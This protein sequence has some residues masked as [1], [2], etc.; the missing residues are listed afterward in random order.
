MP[1]VINA[2][3]GYE[4]VR[5]NTDGKWHN[6]YRGVD[7]GM[8]GYVYAEPGMYMGEIVSFD[9]ASMH[10]TSIIMLNKLGE[11]TQN[12]ADL[13]EARVCIK[14][15][16]YE[17][18]G[19]LFHGKL[20]KYLTSPEE[21]KA[22]SKALKLPL[23]AFYGISFSPYDFP[24]RDDRDKNNIIALR[25]ALFMKTLQDELTNM[26]AK[27][28]HIKTDSCKVLNPDE[29]T[30]DFIL[31]FG[32]KYGYEF[33][34]EAVY[35][36]ICLV[37]DAVFIAK[38]KDG[39]WTATGTQFQVPYIFKTLFTKEPLTFD[40][41]CETKS[42]SKGDIYIDMNEGLP[43]GEHKYVFVGKVGRFTP[44]KEGCGGGQLYRFNEDKYY[45]VAGT[46]G[47]R[48]LE[49]EIVKEL[50]KEK[51]VDES[52]Y[53]SL[54]NEAIE[55]IQ[56]FGDFDQFV[57][58]T[59]PETDFMNPPVTEDEELPWNESEGSNEKEKVA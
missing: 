27:I 19:K 57:N 28:F 43:E 33:E 56:K 18:A 11:Y 47:Y 30:R 26:G 2:F 45:A 24:S 41:F 49:S 39:D 42:V 32:K 8:G 46:K 53:I 51:D 14:H 59:V 4:F 16:D 35:D 7:V 3:P 15:G 52:Y 48:W 55:T 13:K 29:K 25:G 6:M 23:N 50:G 44:I 36:R 20:K 5:S 31:K 21:A 12:Y 1:E 34:I 37:N 58:G 40:D 9:V 54:A 38:Y 10:P 17:A 22:L